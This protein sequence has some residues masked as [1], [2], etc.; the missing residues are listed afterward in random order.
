MAIRYFDPRMGAELSV[1]LVKWGARHLCRFSVTIRNDSWYLMML[2]D[3]GS[4][5]RHECRAPSPTTR[6]CTG[7][8]AACLAW[9]VSPIVLL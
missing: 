3:G 1:L 2:R 4:L 9:L 8:G 5:K 7:M 6:R